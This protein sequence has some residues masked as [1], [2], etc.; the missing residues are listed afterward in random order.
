[1]ASQ[2]PIPHHFKLF[3]WKP[4]ENPLHQNRSIVPPLIL[5]NNR[6]WGQTYRIYYT[7]SS[8]V[9]QRAAFCQYKTYLIFFPSLNRV[10]KQFQCILFKG[11]TT[12][13]RKFYQISLLGKISYRWQLLLQSSKEENIFKGLAL[14][15]R[16]SPS[17]F[18]GWG[19]K[20][21]YITALPKRNFNTKSIH[22]SVH[23]TSSLLLFYIHWHFR[24]SKS[25]LKAK[26][27]HIYN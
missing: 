7:I 12:V 19:H 20:L 10:Y 13:L 21:N 6:R 1:M 9:H 22:N 8:S 18:F 2:A 25:T 14:I 4:R 27:I 11:G 15:S 24:N 5:M 26:C 16:D 23:S 17:Y 3:L